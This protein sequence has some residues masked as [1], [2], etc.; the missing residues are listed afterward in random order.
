MIFGTKHVQT[1][2]NLK[3]KTNLEIFRTKHVQ[4]NSNPTSRLIFGLNKFKQTQTLPQTNL[5][6]KQ[7]QSNSN[8][9]LRLILGHLEQNKFNQ[10]R[11]LSWDNK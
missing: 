10:N 2:S 4:T 7:V 11:T 9:S 8:P 3:F 6:T 1:N 5:G